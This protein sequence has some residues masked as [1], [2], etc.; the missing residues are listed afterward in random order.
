MEPCKILNCENVPRTSGLCARHYA[1]QRIGYGAQERDYSEMPKC[2][3]PHCDDVANSRADKALCDPH[4][5]VKYRGGDPYTR[6]ISG[7]KTRAK[8]WVADCPKRANTKGLCNSHNK[9]AREGKLAVPES[10]GVKLN[11]PCSF[12]GCEKLQHSKGFCRGHYEQNKIGVEMRPLRE[13]GGYSRGEYTCEFKRCKKVAISRG[14]C[15]LHNGKLTQYKISKEE[16]FD[17]YSTPTCYN[18]GCDNTKNLHIDHNHT[19]G[20]VRGL[21]CGGCNTALGHLKESRDRMLGL[22]SYL[23]EY[24]G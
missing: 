18:P 2:D 14:L 16:L 8:C 13:W 24:D 12:E 22:A 11:P 9:R 17:L 7:S 15:A 5:Q 21:L 4:Y 23:D 1:Q 20:K 10:L 6:I 3:V 19:T